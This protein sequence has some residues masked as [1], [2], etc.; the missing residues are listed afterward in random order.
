MLFIVLPLSFELDRVLLVK[1]HTLAVSLIF[2]ELTFVNSAVDEVLNL[3]AAVE[4]AM[5][6]LADVLVVF[7]GKHSESIRLTVPDLAF[8]DD[9]V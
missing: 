1:V 7:A 8:V 6:E 9:I 2:T 5:L 3:S 4:V